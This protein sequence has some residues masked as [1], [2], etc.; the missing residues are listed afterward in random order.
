MHSSAT[1]TQQTSAARAVHRR[2]LLTYRVRRLGRTCSA[3]LLFS[4][5]VGAP[6]LAC[7]QLSAQRHTES[8]EQGA[9]APASEIVTDGPDITEASTVVP[10]GSLQAENGP[11]W[12]TRQHLRTL[13]G[14]ET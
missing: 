9:E 6:P 4:G 14:L 1:S 12:T 5:F 8:A 3:L 11:V 13:D 7:A 2:R 10:Y